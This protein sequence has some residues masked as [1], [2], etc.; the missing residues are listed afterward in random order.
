MYQRTDRPHFVRR[1]DGAE[2]CIDPNEPPGIDRLEYED[3]LAQGNEPAPYVA[4]DTF[5]R[6]CALR[7]QEFRDFRDKVL[8]RIVGIR[9][10]AADLVDAGTLSTA[11][12]VA[13]DEAGKQVREALKDATGHPSVLA[14]IA[15]RD[16]AQ[17]M[18]ALRNIWLSVTATLP[19]AAKQAF[20]KVDK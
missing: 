2:I 11:D 15:A 3:W 16:V 6:D 12:R 10:E 4:P 18:G 7:M 14:A 13:I 5:D 9:Q 19:A 20:A 8:A 1:E 17:L